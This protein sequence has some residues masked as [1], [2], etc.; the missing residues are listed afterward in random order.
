MAIEIFTQL[1]AKGDQL[2]QQYELR[3]RFCI[4]YLKWQGRNSYG[5]FEYDQYDHPFAVYIIWRDV[6]G[7]AR[8]MA[9]FTPCNQ[10]YMIKDHWPHLAPEGALPDGF[11]QWEATRLC[12]EPC[13]GKKM[14]IALSHIMLATEILATNLGIR[15]YWWISPKER[16]ETILP[17]NH[18]YVGVGQKIEYEFCYIGW[19]DAQ[20]MLFP[21]RKE[22]LL[23]DPAFKI[24]E[25]A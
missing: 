8:A 6:D 9:R 3:K 1:T 7:I 4:D 13:L 20:N 23:A 10:P 15:Q 19:S 18:N 24:E 11:D 14:G 5:G 17:H 16:I 12:V 25:A 21:E 22:Q 2:K